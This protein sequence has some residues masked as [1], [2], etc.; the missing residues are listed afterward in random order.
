MMLM[1]AKI[2][3]TKYESIT[4]NELTTILNIFLKFLLLMTTSFIL[5]LLNFLIFNIFFIEHAYFMPNI[6]KLH[7]PSK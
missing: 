2:W 5:V 1:F 3:Y 6:W 4:L 7:K